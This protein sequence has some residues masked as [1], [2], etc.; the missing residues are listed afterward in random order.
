MGFLGL[1]FLTFSLTRVFAVTLLCFFCSFLR[2]GLPLSVEFTCE[3][4]SRLLALHSGFFIKFPGFGLLFSP[5]SF[6]A[7]AGF[8]GS[9]II[10]AVSSTEEPNE[11]SPET[12]LLGC[13]LFFTG[14]TVGA[15]G[16]NS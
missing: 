11:L 5:F 6:W 3:L 10:S 8:A 12:K 13:F 2:W 4:R 16:K 1:V 7:L 14:A 9:S 15:S